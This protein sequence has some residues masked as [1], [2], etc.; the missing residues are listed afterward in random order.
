M[1]ILFL[2]TFAILMNRTIN[3]KTFYLCCSIDNFFF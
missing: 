2:G 1:S 3:I